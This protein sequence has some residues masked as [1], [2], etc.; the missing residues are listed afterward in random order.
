WVSIPRP[1]RERGASGAQLMRP[2]R[3][4]AMLALFC[5]TACGS[6]I[7][8]PP[9]N[10]L[11]DP[12]QPRSLNPAVTVSATGVD[13]QTLHLDSPVSVKF[14]NEDRVAHKFEAALELGDGDCPEMSQLATL[15]PG[16][17]G[18]VAIT[19]SGIICAFHDAGAPTSFAFK[20]LLVVH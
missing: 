11:L 3:A 15:E 12:S 5:S 6:S 2:R 13:P 20:G 14:T 10:S 1:Q 16:Q 4:P 19:R 7:T 18:T 9:T 8:G 17:S